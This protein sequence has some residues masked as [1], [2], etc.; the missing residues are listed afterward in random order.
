MKY[1][2][3]KF[4]NINVI[5]R[6][7]LR[8]Y[9]VRSVISISA[10]QV[11]IS[12]IFIEITGGMCTHM[13]ILNM[14]IQENNDFMFVFIVNGRQPHGLYRYAMNVWVRD[15]ITSRYKLCICR[16]VFLVTY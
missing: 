15:P 14:K 1:R 13:S 4:N 2:K 9:S 12:C 11:S 7:K 5:E 16:P 10:F 8:Y 6:M 3:N